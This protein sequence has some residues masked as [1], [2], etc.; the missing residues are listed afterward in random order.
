MIEHHT[1]Y[2]VH[3]HVI[4]ISLVNIVPLNP[5][6]CGYINLHCRAARSHI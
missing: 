3:V 5:K 4:D 6:L 1:E 2:D